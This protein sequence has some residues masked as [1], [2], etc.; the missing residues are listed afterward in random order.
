VYGSC[1]RRH[2]SLSI[3]LPPECSHC[4][5]EDDTTGFGT[6]PLMYML[7]RA[8]TADVS[9]QNHSGTIFFSRHRN[10]H[11]HFTCIPYPYTPHYIFTQDEDK[12]YAD[13][14]S[15][16]GET[17]SR[18]HQLPIGSQSPESRWSKRV[19]L[20]VLHCDC[21]WSPSDHLISRLSALLPG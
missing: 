21:T 9:A 15:L 19:G 2:V 8:Q 3:A 1:L 12:E 11:R 13:L 18:P 20:H 10:A 6:F 17:S 4:H 14:R 5:P 7:T 16:K